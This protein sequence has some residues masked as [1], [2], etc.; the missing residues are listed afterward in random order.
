M[1]YKIKGGKPIKG[2][3]E[4]LGAKN[5]ATK[6]MI[7]ATLGNAPTELNNVPPIG[8]VDIT[9]NMLENAGV[10][11]RREG[12]RMILDPQGVHEGKTDAHSGS[13]RM[14]ILLVGALLHRLDRVHVPLLGGCTIGARKVNFHLDAIDQFGA[15]IEET[16]G[17]FVATKKGPLKGTHIDLPYPSVGATESCLFLS[18]MAEGTS[19]ISNAAIEPEIAELITMLRSMGAIIY[20]DSGR[21]IKVVGVKELA[22]TSMHILGDRIETASWACLAA[23]SDG[24]ITVTGIRPHIMGNFLSSFREAG[25]GF[26][27]KG[28]KTIRFYRKEEPKPILIETDVY[29]GFSTDWQQPFAIFLTQANGVSVIHET[30]YE[31]RFGYLQMLSKMGAQVQT[32][33]HALGSLPNRF[34]N[35]DNDISAIITGPTPMVATDEV[36]EVPDLRAGLAY[37]VAAAI[38]E[39]TSI[40]KGISMIER[41]YGDIVPRLT[42]MNLDIE[43]VEE[44]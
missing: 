23:A 37:V 19:T 44:I 43:K 7:A 33:K 16:P 20:T 8:D 14:P 40:I 41:G 2:E 5:F 38:A 4:C 21:T 10:S 26:E 1:Y 25:G 22:G 12:K 34:L 28:E 29:P 6:A 11:I 36:L 39:G 18:V 32:T 42:K 17:G 27:L 9:Q 30:V 31:K 3:I 15:T 35:K 13:N 24:D